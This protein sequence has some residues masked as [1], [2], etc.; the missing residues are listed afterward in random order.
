MGR[1]CFPLSII[2]EFRILNIAVQTFKYP[3]VYHAIMFNFR[4]THPNEW[5]FYSQEL[6]L[7]Q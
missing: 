3:Q 4:T 2:E 6:K 1:K 5:F 7:I